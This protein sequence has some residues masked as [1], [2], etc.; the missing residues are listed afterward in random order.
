M[1]LIYNIDKFFQ[2]VLVTAAVEREK[3]VR[4][5]ARQLGTM[6]KSAEDRAWKYAKE[7]HQEAVKAWEVETKLKEAKVLKENWPAS[8]NVHARISSSQQ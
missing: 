7:A 6:R 1:A 2:L 3:K 4:E 5:R 8:R